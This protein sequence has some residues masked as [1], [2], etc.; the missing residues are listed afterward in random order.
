MS[1]G[2]S[3]L[4]ED[5]HFQNGS[6]HTPDDL[7]NKVGMITWRFSDG[8]YMLRLVGEADTTTNSYRMFATDDRVRKFP[9]SFKRIYRDLTDVQD[10][11]P[12]THAF[13][14]F[15][16]CLEFVAE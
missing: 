14:A 15:M 3:S 7:I 13:G 10:V 6:L 11:T 9:E 5:R 1:A 2:D 12:T 16:Q 4:Q 8:S